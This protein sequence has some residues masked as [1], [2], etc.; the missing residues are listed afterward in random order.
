[1]EG[2]EEGALHGDPKRGVGG[3]CDGES[4]GAK[5]F[6][7]SA[8]V[9]VVSR[10]AQAEGRVVREACGVGAELRLRGGQEQTDDSGQSASVVQEEQS[11]PLPEGQIH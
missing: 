9:A 2:R 6:R 3:L 5:Q 11:M 8:R 7:E 4:G 10:A 1:M